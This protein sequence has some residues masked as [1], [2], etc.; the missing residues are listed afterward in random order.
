MLKIGAL[1]SLGFS[2]Y[3]TGFNLLVFDELIDLSPRHKE[4]G[5]GLISK[6]QTK[7]KQYFFSADFS[8]TFKY[9]PPY[10]TV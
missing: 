4:R 8:F 9:T 10:H 6:K 7:T 1:P 2:D 5:K 3:A